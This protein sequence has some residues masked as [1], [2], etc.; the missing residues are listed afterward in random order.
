MGCVAYWGLMERSSGEHHLGGNTQHKVLRLNTMDNT[1]I[2]RTT[3]M[4]KCSRQRQRWSKKGSSTN[5]GYKITTNFFTGF[6]CPYIGHGRL[7]L[8]V[9]LF[10]SLTP[11]HHY[12]CRNTFTPALTFPSVTRSASPFQ[13]RFVRVLCPLRSVPVCLV[14]GDGQHMARLWDRACP[15]ESTGP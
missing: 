2:R 15:A 7:R 9:N 10:L 13:T 14:I 5:S 12:S 1:L 3:H 4:Y 11:S 8:S 6:P